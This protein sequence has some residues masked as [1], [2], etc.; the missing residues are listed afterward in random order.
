MGRT[1]ALSFDMG[2]TEA[3]SFGMG[4]TEALSF[5][6]GA[7]VPVGSRATGRGQDSSLR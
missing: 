7:C 2:R 4:R 3:L 5:G 6:Y 1:E